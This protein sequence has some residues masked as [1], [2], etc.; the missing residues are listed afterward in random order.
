M[1]DC[2][3]L[4]KSFARVLMATDAIARA[5]KV[6]RSEVEEGLK[7]LNV[8]KEEWFPKI[9]RYDETLQLLVR[10]YNDKRIAGVRV[11]ASELQEAFLSEGLLSLVACECRK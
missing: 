9:P 2:S 6:S 1:A 3:K 4:A 7:I 11:Y 8:E 5:D 10:S